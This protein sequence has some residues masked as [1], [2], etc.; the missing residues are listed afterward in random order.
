MGD[1]ACLRGTTRVEFGRRAGARIAARPREGYL[2]M[3]AHA[4]PPTFSA[5]RQR[6]FAAGLLLF[7]VALS[8]QYSCKVLDADH[9]NRSAFQRWREQILLFAEDGVNIWESHNY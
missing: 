3:D 5:A 4:L 2:A 1:S 7:F 9:N 6:W 8:V